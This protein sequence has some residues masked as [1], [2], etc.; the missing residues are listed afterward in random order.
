MKC[1][2]YP[3]KRRCSKGFRKKSFKIIAPKFGSLE[4]FA[5]FTSETRNTV[6]VQTKNIPKPYF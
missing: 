6:L 2:N 3:L 1:S 5:T 4:N